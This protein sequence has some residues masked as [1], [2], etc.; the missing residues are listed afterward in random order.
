MHADLFTLKWAI[1]PL[2]S[3]DVPN[4]MKF[5]IYEITSLGDRE[6]A[7]DSSDIKDLIWFTT[8]VSFVTRYPL[9][10]LKVLC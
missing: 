3:S 1:Q 10:I 4:N 8:P 6:V 5:S 9:L 2:K 7:A